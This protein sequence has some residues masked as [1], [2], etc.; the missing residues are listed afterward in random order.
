MTFY[1]NI[2]AVGIEITVS[3]GA[4]GNIAYDIVAISSIHS[5]QCYSHILPFSCHSPI[6]QFAWL[7]I[8]PSKVYCVA[9]MRHQQQCEAKA[10]NVTINGTQTPMHSAH[11]AFLL[12][13]LLIRCF[14][15][16]GFFFPFNRIADLVCVCDQFSMLFL[17][18]VV[19]L[20]VLR[21]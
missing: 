2:F 1:K 18:V 10:V 16:F 17:A 20:T 14:V 11:S 3:S 13:L 8:R 21:A 7:L 15:S 5:L 19:M 9:K 4:S 12:S 6:Y